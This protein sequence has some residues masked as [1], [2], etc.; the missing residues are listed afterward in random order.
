MT[1][2]VASFCV[3]IGDVACYNHPMSDDVRHKKP[4][5]LTVSIP[6]ELA[7]R[8]EA[9]GAMDDRRFGPA[10]VRLAKEGLRV[11][12]QERHERGAQK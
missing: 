4:R 7:E 6:W 10:L 11:R 12:E 8:I 5:R 1:P 9:E 3:S 2:R